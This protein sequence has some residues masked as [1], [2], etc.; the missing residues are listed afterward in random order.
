MTFTVK[1][2]PK[3][4]TD[5]WFLKKHYAHRLPCISYAFGLYGE[6]GLCGVCSFG[7]P[8]NYVEMEAWKP[9]ELLELNRLCVEDGL[10]K[11]TLSFFVSQC[12][13]LL[14]Q[15]R[16]LISY[17]DL[18]KGHHGYIYQA[19]NW[20]YTGVG[21]EGCKVYIMKDGSE[22]HQRHGEDLN[23]DNIDHIELT[24]GKARY[25]MFIGNKTDRKKMLTKLR[26]TVLPYPKGDNIRY[27]SSAKI[28]N[29]QQILF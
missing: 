9:W 1:Q 21:G 19:T 24:V 29:I 26:F 8:P 20:L 27:D 18:G 25:Y 16:V 11:N 6:N 5:E 15:P 2:I 14:P 4:E 7:M 10:P 28:D 23:K 13:K 3:S 22:K 12:F 17:A